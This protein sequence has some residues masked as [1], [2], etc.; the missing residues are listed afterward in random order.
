MI[1]DISSKEGLHGTKQ[2]DVTSNNSTQESLLVT[3]ATSLSEDEDEVPVPS[4]IEFMTIS[5]QAST[6]SDLSC[7]GHINGRTGESDLLGLQFVTEE[8]PENDEFM[9]V[10]SI[11][12]IAL[13]HE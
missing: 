3:I 6:D 8:L 5:R 13:T 1:L 10:Q 2:F 7:Y 9:S 11:G 12:S 4:E